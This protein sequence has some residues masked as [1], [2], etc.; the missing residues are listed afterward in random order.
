MVIFGP[1]DQ[2]GWAR[3]S[4]MVTSA[5]SAL[6]APAERPAGRGEHDAAHPLA[7][8]AVG[9]LGAQALVDGAVLAVDGD[10]LAGARL[11][12]HPPHDRARPR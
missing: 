7:A 2:V 6:R 9:V 1:I 4:S 11:L 10:Q 5:S 12:A 8:G 3:A